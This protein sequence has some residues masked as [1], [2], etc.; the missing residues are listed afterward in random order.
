MEEQKKEE[1]PLALA[2]ARMSQK[3]HT[4]KIAGASG[5]G[6]ICGKVIRRTSFLET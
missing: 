6:K 2:I 3:M 1:I 5:R 4:I